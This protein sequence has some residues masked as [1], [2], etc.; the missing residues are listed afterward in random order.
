[1][2]IFGASFFYSYLRLAS[3]ELC[4]L[5]RLVNVHALQVV[6]RGDALVVLHVRCHHVLPELGCSRARFRLGVT[7]LTVAFVVMFVVRFF[8]ALSES[9]IPRVEFVVTTVVSILF[10]KQTSVAMS[11]LINTV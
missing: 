8:F 10:G 4:T 11:F 7:L 3:R 1:M 6:S 9:T 2:D 5:R